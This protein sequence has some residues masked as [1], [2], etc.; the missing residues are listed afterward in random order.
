[1]SW[2]RDLHTELKKLEAQGDVYKWKPSTELVQFPVDTTKGAVV[3]AQVVSDP[4]L[5]HSLLVLQVNPHWLCAPCLSVS[6]VLIFG[7]MLLAGRVRWDHPV[8]YT[9]HLHSK[10]LDRRTVW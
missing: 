10:R 5:G 7:V 8:C 4:R 2:L 3:G 6:R 1:M 9:P